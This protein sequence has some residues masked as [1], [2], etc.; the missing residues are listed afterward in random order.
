[1][2]ILSLTGFVIYS[3]S[4][5]PHLQMRDNLFFSKEFSE[6]EGVKGLPDRSVV[7]NPPALQ[8][9]RETVSSFAGSERSL[10]EEIAPHSNG[11]PLQWHPTPVLLPGKSHGQKSLVACSPCCC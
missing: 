4:R 3:E 11:T 9:T 2:P 1:M 7:Q 5:S 10:E 8:E 6:N